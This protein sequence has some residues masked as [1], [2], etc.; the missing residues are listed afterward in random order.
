MNT[1]SASSRSRIERRR[2]S[3][4]D[5]QG[6][7]RVPQG[8]PGP[9]LGEID[10]LSGRYPAAGARRL[11]RREEPARVP[12]APPTL[13]ARRVNDRALRPRVLGGSVRR[14]RRPDRRQRQER[15]GRHALRSE[16][17]CLPSA[18]D[19][20]RS[21]PVRERLPA[22]G[23][24]LLRRGPEGVTPIA[25]IAALA[26]SLA[27]NETTSRAI[28]EDALARIADPG[29]EGGRVYTKV[30]AQAALAAADASD[31]MRKQGIAPT[32]LAGLPVSVKDLFDVAGDV[33]T[34]GS[35]VLRDRPN[36]AVDAVAVARLRA[37]GAVVIGRSNM[38]EFAFSGIGIN[39]HFGTPANPWDRAARR[40][41]GGSS[42]GAAV[43]V[44][45]G[46]AAFALGTD[47]GG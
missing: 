7:H 29:G 43:S 39:P 1:R 47:T 44:A 21:V 37:A 42:S 26:R 45:D 4:G 9:R 41:P 23:D 22:S 36:A 20:A 13:R 12:H 32:A 33:T 11:P 14:V 40:I 18:G 31:R 2:A 27:R 46:M 28:V 38:T 35:T 25:P 16:H 6:A 15:Q 17:V 19:A 24:A 5:P 34:A 10:R 8:R 30:H 3:D